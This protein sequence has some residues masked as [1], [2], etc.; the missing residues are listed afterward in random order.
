MHNIV[1]CGNLSQTKIMTNLKTSILEDFDAKVIIPE[2]QNKTALEI[3][4]EWLSN[5]DEADIVIIV[6]NSD[7]PG[8]NG[9]SVEWLGRLDIGKNITYELAYA[10][11]QNISVVV[12]DPRRR[13]ITDTLLKL[14][15]VKRDKEE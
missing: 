14:G 3:D 4:I 1:I 7:P 15:F 5:M 9:T 12:Y 13:S 8:Y 6:P 11:H 10:I 2:V